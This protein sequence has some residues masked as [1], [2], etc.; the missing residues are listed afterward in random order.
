MT[1]ILGNGV[2]EVESN[3]ILSVGRTEIHCILD[4]IRR[5]MVKEIKCKV[6]MG[7]NDADAVSGLDVLENEIAEQGRF[8]RARAP[9]GV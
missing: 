3:R 5:N 1:M 2:K 6:A 4:S 8:S 7:I 9:Y